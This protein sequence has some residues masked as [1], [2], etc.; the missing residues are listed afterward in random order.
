MSGPP[1]EPPALRPTPSRPD[2]VGDARPLRWSQW[3]AVRSLDGHVLVTAGAGTGK[4]FTVVS[5]FL[6]LLGIPIRTPD[7]TAAA[8]RPLDLHEIAAIT[9]TNQAASELKRSLREALRAHGRP[10]LARRVDGARVGTIHR[11]CG[12]ILREFALRTGRDPSLR[13]LE[14]GEA[15]AL[16]RTVARE[17]LIDAVESSVAEAK[18]LLERRSVREVEG[19]I[20][21][22][23]DQSDVLRALS[24]STRLDDDGRDLVRLAQRASE[25]LDGTLDDMGAVDFDRMIVWTRDLLREDPRAL[26]TLRRRVRVLII[27]EFQDVDPAQKDIAYL[28]G[29]LEARTW[30]PP[31]HVPRPASAEAGRR[32]RVVGP[33]PSIPD[34]V[35]R[36]FLVGDP[37]QSI[38]RFRRADVT[39]W[40]RVER[41]LAAGRGAVVPLDESFRA[42]PEL[43]GW[44]D[45]TSGMHLDRPLDG[46]AHAD[47]EVPYRALGATRPAS[48]DAAVEL[49][50][51]PAGRDGKRLPNDV[52][53][54]AEGA[55]IARRARALHD[56]GTPWREMALLVPAWTNVGHYE[57]ALAEARIPAYTVRGEGFLER[58]EIVD[59]ITAL[60][61]IR[62]PRDDRALFGFLRGPFVGVRDDTLL[63]VA[64]HAGRPY[65]AALARL[66]RGTAE[67]HA[68]GEGTATPGALA[69]GAGEEALLR[70]GVALIDRLG[71]LR[72]RVPVAEL[73]QRLIDRTGYVAHL[74]LAGQPGLEAI[75]NLRHFLEMARAAADR[76]VGDFL[77]DLAE[78]R[79]RERD[80]V[81]R[82]IPAR[83]YAEDD[84]VVT[85]TTIHGAKGLEWDVVFCADIARAWRGE[86]EAFL[87]VDDTLL[88]GD[89]D[90]PAKERPEPWPSVA[91]RLK[92]EDRAERKRQWYVAQTRA[93]DRLL[94]ASLP[95]GQKPSSGSFARELTDTFPLL[96]AALEGTVP[97]DGAALPYVSA[98]G[99]SHEGRIAVLSIEEAEGAARSEAS[100]HGDAGAD[101]VGGAPPAIGE[102]AAAVLA[103]PPPPVATPAGPQRLSAT[104]LLTRSR[105]EKRYHLKYVLRIPE[106]EAERHAD[107]DTLIRAVV[108]GQIVH[109]V[110]HRYRDP[111]EL[112]DVIEVAIGRWD[113]AAPPPDTDRGARYRAE[114]REEVDR[115]LAMPEY[116]ALRAEEGARRELRFLQVHPDGRATEGAIDL[117]VG[118]AGGREGWRL[119]DVKTNRV[120]GAGIAAVA[121]GYAPQRD[122][123]VDATGSISDESVATFTFAF[124]G[125]GVAVSE[126]P[127]PGAS[128]RTAAM[129]DAIAE[130][131]APALAS[132]PAECVFCGYRV[133]GLCPGVARGVPAPPA[134]DPAPGAE[135]SPLTDV[136]PTSDAAPS[137]RPALPSREHASVDPPK[138]DRKASPGEQLGLFE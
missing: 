101:P 117:A 42:S 26:R 31:E 95:L 72:D 50:I 96:G 37:K 60:Q 121:A 113:E 15:A 130:G 9:F 28:L 40:T 115:V 94:L 19:W 47:F 58:R 131:A 48:N 132:D 85:I 97:T 83:L 104:Q 13:V 57:D 53:R 11:F 36:L 14:E 77:A 35:T 71:G 112:A 122:V 62:A 136:A 124:S 33:P 59:L 12:D 30:S 27:D 45:A 103:G 61:A 99:A 64:R 55:W 4:T 73:L 87:R 135:G 138:P 23:L 91:E 67:G 49:L 65:W 80:R 76:S 46:V 93:R 134:A 10:D 7:G 38:Y 90:V 25:R 22:L 24:G 123:Y 89:P 75:A 34:N 105:C 56:A 88:L 2:P 43:L 84:D 70:H 51:L 106:P 102:S 68:E 69:G 39:V 129:R 16:A 5:A 17:S 8:E 32:G 108:R 29:G 1:L 109:D 81:S 114:L 128:A 107:S 133:V 63:R 6:Y 98:T 111:Q 41:E 86:P 127:P 92:A 78:R 66:A 52:S 110:L 18:R 100:A 126:P 54:R 20:A 137:M 21:A 119:V 116:A 125:P 120:E 3:N 79:E 82:E 44:V 74:A 118:P